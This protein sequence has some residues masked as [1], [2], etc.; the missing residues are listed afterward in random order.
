MSVKTFIDTN[1]WVYL[2][3][4]DKKSKFAKDII[5]SK[6]DNIVISTQVLNEFF[7][8]IAN[9]HKIKSKTDAKIIVQELIESFIV[10]VV[11]NETILQAIDVSIK[12]KLNYFDSLMIASALSENCNEFYSEDMHHG[13]IINES[14]KIVNPFKKE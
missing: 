5:E 6:F 3:S 8:V 10:S 13:L 7:N 2:F 12:Y 4:N 11:N 9:K 1:V 14:L